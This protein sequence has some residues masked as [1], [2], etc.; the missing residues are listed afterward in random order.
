MTAAEKRG[1]IVLALVFFM[2]MLGLFMLVP[3]LALYAETLPG[4]TPFLIGVAIGIYGLTQAVFQ[5][6]LGSLSDRI[7]RRP[8]I[9]VGLALFC[10][11][12]LVAAA[13]KSIWPIIV[14]RAIQGSGAVSGAT[15]AL[16]ADLSRDNQR[17]KVMGIIGISIGGAFTSAFVLG[18]VLNAAFGLSGLFLVSAALALIGIPILLY[19]VPRAPAVSR[20]SAVVPLRETLAATDLRVLYVGVLTLHLVLAASFVAIPVA[21]VQ[22]MQVPAAA[23]YTVYLPVLLL[24]IVF[25]APLLRMSGRVGT[26]RILFYLSIL[27]LALAEALVYLCW[28]SKP[29]MYA[30]LT[31][32]FL[33]VNFLEAALPGFISRAA[34]RD[35]KGTALG[36]YSTFQFVGVFAGGLSGGGIASLWGY[37][38]VPVVCAVICCAWFVGSLLVPAEVLSR[39]ARD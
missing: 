26:G 8:I 28:D 4:A 21:L 38:A 35:G 7:G 23:H 9:V 13:A 39:P 27:T 34:P 5:I 18:P 12:S 17:T 11:G 6:P 3:V 32:Y 29:G 37:T 1:A 2:R 24:S 31:L 20:G 10:A 36:A 22:G 33:A 16:A 15:L 14:G 19:G 30:A 25:V